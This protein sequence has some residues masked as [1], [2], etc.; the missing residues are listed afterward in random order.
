[1]TKNSE[2]ETKK[3]LRVCTLEN[4]SC[5]CELIDAH[6]KLEEAYH[7]LLM[8]S[9]SYHKADEFRF[10]LHAF[11]QSLRGVT[12]MLQNYKDII[13]DFEK[14]Y[15]KK[16]E[17]MKN[18]S[19]LKSIC[20]TRTI[21]VHQ[22]SLKP[23]SKVEIGVYRGRRLKVGLIIHYDNPFLDSKI[24]FDNLIPK[25]SEIGFIDK[26]HSAIGEQL[27]IRRQWFCEELGD[28]EIFW[29]CYQAYIHICDIMREAHEFFE[30]ELVPQGIPD[31][32]FEK[33]Y[34]LLESDLDPSLPEK[35]GW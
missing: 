15:S 16:Q 9:F 17:E 28:E 12:F 23:K 18:D 26:E 20:S 1:M 21:V 7:F 32:Y 35:W 4:Y 27:G 30:L 3:K 10:N 2:K 24:I 5:V 11:I 14:W 25:F 34:V 19:C 33:T 22:R 31:D 8:M 29:T 13:P 6:D